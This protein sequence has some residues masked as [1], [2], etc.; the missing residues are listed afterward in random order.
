[1]IGRTN[2]GGA[3]GGT[4]F[5]YIGVIY[6]V[7]ATLTCSDGRKTLRAKDTTGMYVF[8]VPYAATWTVTSVQG[9]S[10]NS[11]NVVISTLW[12]D[13]IVN[14]SGWDGTFFDRGDQYV[15][16]TGGWAINSELYYPFSNVS[17]SHADTGSI[18]LTMYALL[19]TY[20]TEC[21]FQNLTP[22]DLKDY[23]SITIDYSVNENNCL[24]FSLANITSG[25]ATSTATRTA[26]TTLQKSSQQITI[27]LT[28]S[29]IQNY[30]YNN[31]VYATV[32][33]AVASSGYTNVEAAISKIKASKS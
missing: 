19:Q 33:V 16:V 15:D 18:G 8:G 25:N 20:Q 17:F 27:D 6:P 7:G 26:N 13:E 28:S 23:R 2:V 32:G 30:L 21:V 29:E 12:Q 24:F 14:L 22:I 9:S 11:E 10:T 1:M 4:A 5:A 3:G 31:L